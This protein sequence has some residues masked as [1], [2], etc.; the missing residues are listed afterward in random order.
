VRA[1]L[2]GVRPELTEAERAARREAIERLDRVRERIAAE[3]G[4]LPDSTPG[5]REEHE[6]WG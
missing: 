4:V 5:I 6:S 1:I 3:H 2:H